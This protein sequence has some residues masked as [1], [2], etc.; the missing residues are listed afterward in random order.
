ML[1]LYFAYIKLKNMKINFPISLT[2]F[3]VDTRNF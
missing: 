3:N 1:K 2:F